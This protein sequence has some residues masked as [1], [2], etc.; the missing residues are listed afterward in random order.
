MQL[1]NTSK[2]Y[3]LITIALHWILAVTFI[4]LFALGFWMVDLDYYS[5]WYHQAPWIHK[6][7]GILAVALM[8]LRL[9]W[10]L[11]NTQPEGLD[12]PA[13]NKAAHGVHHLFYVMIF[14]LGVSGYLI[15]TAEG[16]A[17]SV[18]DWFAVP[19]LITP[20]EGQADLAGEIHE[21]LGYGLIAFV[22]LHAAASLKH[23]LIDKDNT[24]KRML[25]PINVKHE[26]NK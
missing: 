14:L 11:F 23:H 22:I 4:G 7:L 2:T 17:I 24:L 15:S 19:A 12:K 1:T 20:F 5:T 9:V 3:G 6:S 13:L 8:L 25:W 26:S 10:K 16:D 18:F 21:W